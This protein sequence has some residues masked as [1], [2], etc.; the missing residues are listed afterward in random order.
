M[1]QRL[2]DA[3]IPLK[4]VL[5]RLLQGEKQQVV[6]FDI[7]PVGMIPPHSHAAQWGVVIEGEMALTIDGKSTTYRAGDSYYIPAGVVHSAEFK[8]KFKAVDVF[9]EPAR[10]RVRKK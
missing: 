9:D 3:D 5:G 7:D 2:P 6:F 4:G 1:I 8:T 10:Y